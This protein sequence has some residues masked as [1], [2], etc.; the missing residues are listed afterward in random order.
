MVGE[1]K[2]GVFES[3]AGTLWVD[4]KIPTD[5]QIEARRPNIIIQ[6]WTAKTIWIVDIACP[7]D[8]LVLDREKEKINTGD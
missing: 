1:N 8:P 3:A 2:S 6:N 4:T 7:W 5:E